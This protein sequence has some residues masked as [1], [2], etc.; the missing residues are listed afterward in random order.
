MR[1]RLFISL[2]LLF[3]F[4][5]VISQT[6]TKKRITTKG[7]ATKK[8]N[9]IK[10]VYNINQLTG[11]WQEVTRRSITD[12]ARVPFTDSL[13][14]NFNKRDSVIVRDGISI[15]QAGFAS[16]AAGNSLQVA[17]DE[18]AIISLTKNTLIVNDGEF[19]RNLQKRKIFYSETLGK[20]IIP[21]ENLSD[22]VSIN[23]KKTIGKWSIYR[24][25]AA[26]GAAEDSAIIK[27]IHFTQLNEDG[28]VSGEV[29]FT[30]ADKNVTLPFNAIFDKGTLQINTLSHTWNLNTYK[31]DGKELVFGKHGGLVYFAKPL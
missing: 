20:I 16:I 1:F 23:V 14:L 5:N 17:G 6:V 3:I 22:S 27:G 13:Q 10:P 30:K 8:T 19:I 12:N 25:Q 31:A 7:S 24:T 28:S 11:K 15:S 2:I 9:A 26:P 4:S 29:H 21:K 18:Y